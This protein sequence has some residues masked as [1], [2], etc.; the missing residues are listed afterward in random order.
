MQKHSEK[1]VPVSENTEILKIDGFI[2]I[3]QSFLK[4]LEEN[5]FS[6]LIIGL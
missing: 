3:S 2:F 1:L 5:N 4:K 6:L